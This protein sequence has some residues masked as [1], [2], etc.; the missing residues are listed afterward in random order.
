[1]SQYDRVRSRMLGGPVNLSSIWISLPIVHPEDRE[2]FAL[3]EV[4][5]VQNLRIDVGDLLAGFPRLDA[6]IDDMKTTP[7]SDVQAFPCP[8]V[9]EELHFGEQT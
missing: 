1:L 7:H 4:I 3:H 8:L 9:V 6:G 5:R 2:A